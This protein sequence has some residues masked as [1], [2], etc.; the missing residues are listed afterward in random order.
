MSNIQ[1]L[2]GE[3]EAIH[4]HEAVPVSVR[5]FFPANQCHD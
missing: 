5:G 2:T 4:N 3:K 1:L